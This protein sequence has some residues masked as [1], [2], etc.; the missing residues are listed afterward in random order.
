MNHG[1]LQEI[2]LLKNV[3][4]LILPKTLEASRKN[5]YYVT[6][7]NIGLFRFVYIKP[8]FLLYN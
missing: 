1:V 5:V 6:V 3:Q 2:K 7:C 8:H 4:C